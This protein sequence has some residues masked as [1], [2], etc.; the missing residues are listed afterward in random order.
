VLLSIAKKHE[1]L[2]I[3]SLKKAQMNREFVKELTLAFTPGCAGPAGAN[4]YPRPDQEAEPAWGQAR[5]AHRP[6]AMLG[7]SAQERAQKH[8][9]S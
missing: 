5:K 3:L 6:A 7:Q 4:W 2:K 1:A 8:D 9:A